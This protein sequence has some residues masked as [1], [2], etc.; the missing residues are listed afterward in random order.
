MYSSEIRHKDWGSHTNP[1]PLHIEVEELFGLFVRHT[2]ALAQNVDHAL[3][4]ID[5]DGHVIAPGDSQYRCI[6]AISE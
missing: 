6:V 5:H 1:R 3:R 2:V 4:V